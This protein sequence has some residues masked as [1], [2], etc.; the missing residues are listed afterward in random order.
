MYISISIYIHISKNGELSCR[1]VA[2]FHLSIEIIQLLL[3]FLCIYCLSSL[4]NLIC[5]MISSSCFKVVEL[6]ISHYILIPCNAAHHITY[7]LWHVIH[8]TRYIR[9]CFS[10]HARAAVRGT[11]HRPHIWRSSRFFRISCLRSFCPYRGF[12]SKHSCCKVMELI[13]R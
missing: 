5:F 2:D 4:F 6:H 8:D 13:T 10:L 11:G 9:R 3:C 7:N 12:V 1:D